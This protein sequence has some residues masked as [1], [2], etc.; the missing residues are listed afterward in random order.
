MKLRHAAA[1]AAIGWYLMLPPIPKTGTPPDTT[2]PLNTWRSEG[3]FDTA[4]EC[5][6]YL[7][8]LDDLNS[9]RRAH[10][11]ASSNPARRGYLT[12][13]LLA[14]RCIATDDPR[15]KPN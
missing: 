4:H 3:A 12:L 11:F 6:A 1:L 14:G 5:Q 13:A 8:E 9:Q 2:A 15:L 10:L 7:V